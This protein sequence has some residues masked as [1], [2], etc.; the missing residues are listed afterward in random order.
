MQTFLPFRGFKHSAQ[1]LDYK[2]LGKQRIEALQMLQIIL[3]I[4]ESNWKFHPCTKM[5]K[6]YP[7]ALCFYGMNMCKEWIKRGYKDTTMPRFQT[8]CDNELKKHKLVVPHWYDDERFHASHRS[9]LLF[10]NEAFYNQYG[11]QEIPKL[12]YYWPTKERKL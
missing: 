3:G 11:W 1:V 4:K 8:I 6:P 9:A 10:K 7:K 5:W 12:E 2:R